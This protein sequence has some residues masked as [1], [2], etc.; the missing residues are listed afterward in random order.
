[1][2]KETEKHA[3]DQK[4]IEKEIWKRGAERGE[5]GVK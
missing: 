1:M 2:K 5:T 4:K 3:A